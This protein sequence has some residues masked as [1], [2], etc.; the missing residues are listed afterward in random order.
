M[1]RTR[2]QVDPKE[3]PGWRSVES[4]PLTRAQ[5]RELD[6]RLSDSKDR[7]RYLLATA[8]TPKHALFYDVS[9]DTFVMDDPA[10][11]TLFKRRPA[12]EAIRALLRSRVK[13]I[14]CRVSPA[15]S[16]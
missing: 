1:P 8:L 3:E 16:S 15:R 7:T 12:A 14:R 10:L 2:D 5:I 11:G 4:P 6:H 13:V 9:E